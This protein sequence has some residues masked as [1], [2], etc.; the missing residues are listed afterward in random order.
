MA[1]EIEWCLEG[2]IV[3]DPAQATHI[4][5]NVACETIFSDALSVASNQRVVTAEVSG[6]LLCLSLCLYFFLVFSGCGQALAS[7]TVPMKTDMHLT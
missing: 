6:M 2:R 3:D 7:S 4:V 5:V 1:A